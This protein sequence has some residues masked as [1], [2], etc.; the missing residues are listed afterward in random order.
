MNTTEDT[1]DISPEW[2]YTRKPGYPDGIAYDFITGHGCLG[3]ELVVSNWCLRKA[4]NSPIGQ[5]AAQAVT[6]PLGMGIAAPSA[7][8]IAEKWKAIY[9]QALSQYVD[10]WQRQ[11][12]KLLGDD[13]LFAKSTQIRNRFI[14]RYGNMFRDA[15]EKRLDEKTQGT[16]VAALDVLDTKRFLTEWG[17]LEWPEYK[18][19]LT[20]EIYSPRVFF[21]AAPLLHLEECHGVP[22]IIENRPWP[23]TSPPRRLLHAAKNGF[24]KKLPCGIVA[25]TERDDAVWIVRR[26]SKCEVTLKSNRNVYFK[27][28]FSRLYDQLSTLEGIE[29][30]VSGLSGQFTALAKNSEALLGMSGMRGKLTAGNKLI[31]TVAQQHEAMPPGTPRIEILREIAKAE[32]RN[33]A[34]DPHKRT[35]LS[36]KK[37]SGIHRAMLAGRSPD[38]ADIDQHARS[39]ERC[40]HRARKRLVA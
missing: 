8:D 3:F 19:T 36:A 17:T 10:G 28:Q 12:C 24:D 22:Y 23:D 9:R 5:P 35:W 25:L 1:F 16:T 31:K 32:M 4:D 37:A 11:L 26:Y 38:R 14:E 18:I 2:E 6:A 34:M 33:V 29:S 40:Y 13:Q 39:L 21:F 15:L 20:K 7:S 27:S 30:Q